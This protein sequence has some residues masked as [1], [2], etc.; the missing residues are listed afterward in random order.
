MTGPLVV[1]GV[2]TRR[3][4]LAQ[5]S[6]VAAFLGPVGVLEH[7]LEP[8]VGEAT[9]T[10]AA[11]GASTSPR[12]TEYVLDR[13]GGRRSRSRGIA[14]AFARLKPER[15]VPKSA[16]AGGSRASSACS[17]NKYYVDEVVRRSDRQAGRRR[18]RADLLWRGVDVGLIDGFASSTAVALDL[19]RVRRL[20]RFAAAVGTGRARTPGCS[21]S[22]C[23]R[24]SAPSAF[25]NPAIRMRD[26]FL[27]SIGYDSWILPALLD[28]SAARRGVDLGRMASS[29]NG[30]TA[31]RS[32]AAPRARSRCSRCSPSPSSSSSRSACG[33]ASTRRTPAGSSVVDM[34][35][36]PSWGIRFTLG[37]DGIARDD[38]A[39]HDA[40]S[41]CSRSCGSW[42]SIRTQG[43][44]RTTRCCSCSRPACSAS[45]WRSISSC[46]T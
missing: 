15:L 1:L 2:L 4:R 13:A 19:A 22:A 8:V 41:C 40:S 7:W 18:C 10:R 26:A 38:G 44:Q 23:S 43:A 17:L 14:L 5:H 46:S 33:G 42:T 24:C 3:R 37:V 25:A 30:P 16:V 20:D 12:S 28:H 11:G 39:A 27:T 6:G 21:S 29:A 34:P 9:A 45:S 32:R 35:W 31:T 36:I